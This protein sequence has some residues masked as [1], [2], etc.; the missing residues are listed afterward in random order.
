MSET[1]DQELKCPYCGSGEVRDY[2]LVLP[3][4]FDITGIGVVYA[5]RKKTIE[6]MCQNCFDIRA[7][8]DLA[9]VALFHRAGTISASASEYSHK[10]K[11]RLAGAEKRWEFDWDDETSV[12]CRFGHHHPLGKIITPSCDL[13]S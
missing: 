8:L 9:I 2:D 1:T 5:G 13:N 7:H 10:A 11:Y 6:S 4:Y 12:T 3:Y